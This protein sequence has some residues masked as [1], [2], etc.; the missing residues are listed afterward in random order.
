MSLGTRQTIIFRTNPPIVKSENM[1]R[2][3]SRFGFHLYGVLAGNSSR[4][5]IQS[6]GY[7]LRIQLADSEIINP[8]IL[9]RTGHMVYTGISSLREVQKFREGFSEI[10][11]ALTGFRFST[12]VSREL[13]RFPL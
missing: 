7:G 11:L 6:A 4:R 12:A 8:D 9:T 5:G 2:Q 10:I 3:E 1:Y 13:Y